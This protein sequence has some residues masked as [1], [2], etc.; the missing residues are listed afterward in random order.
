M[1]QEPLNYD[2]SKLVAWLHLNLPSLLHFSWLKRQRRAAGKFERM[3]QPQPQVLPTEPQLRSGSSDYFD[4]GY[5]Q[6][7]NKSLNQLCRSRWQAVKQVARSQ[8]LAQPEESSID[9]LRRSSYYE[10]KQDLKQQ[11]NQCVI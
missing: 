11:L 4:G 8:Y 6:S 9:S 3:K 1:E 2:E 5:D 10:A 7:R